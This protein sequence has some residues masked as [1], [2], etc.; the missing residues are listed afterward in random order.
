MALR[1]SF[2]QQEAEVVPLHAAG[3][4]KLVYHHVA[5]AAAQLFIDERAVSLGHQ[6]VQQCVGVC[7]Q[8]TVCFMVEATNFLVYMVQ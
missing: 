8:E 6:V 2:G 3:V 4:L 7:Q 5:N 1:Q